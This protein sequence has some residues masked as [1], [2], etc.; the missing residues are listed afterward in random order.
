MSES[1][2]Q[3]KIQKIRQELNNFSLSEQNSL[4][5]YCKNTL[6]PGRQDFESSSIINL[7][8]PEDSK[9]SPIM[10]SSQ[11]FLNKDFLFKNQSD[12]ELK[13]SGLEHFLKNDGQLFQSV[14]EQE[15]IKHN[16]KLLL[17][18]HE[19]RA[20]Y[21]QALAEKDDLI[22]KYREK[23]SKDDSD[24]KNLRHGYLN[25]EDLKDSTRKLIS[26]SDKIEK[27]KHSLNKEN[28]VLKEKLEKAEE[29]FRKIKENF[30]V[31][32]EQCK[33]L[34]ANNSKS[35]RKIEELK[36]ENEFL[37]KALNK[38]K[39]ISRNSSFSPIKG[40]G[41]ST[42]IRKSGLM[43]KKP[44]F[45]SDGE[46]TERK[47]PSPFT[48]SCKFR[49]T[50]GSKKDPN[51]DSSHLTTCK[52]VKE[53]MTSLSLSSATLIIPQLKSMVEDLKSFKPF[54]AF[55][56]KM[57]K[58]VCQNSPPNTFKSAPTSKHSLMWI[59]RLIKEY[60]D[61]KSGEVSPSNSKIL[62]VLKA[63]LNTKNTDDIPKAISKLLVENEKLLKILEKVKGILKLGANTTL[64]EFD[65]ELELRGN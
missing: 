8:I 19:T 65:R 3:E 36:K 46:R 63:G 11:K 55:F 14:K 62:D 51:S 60:L 49:S 15:L 33:G 21:I 10:L 48:R 2:I 12:T 59:K 20:Y 23:M 34:I 32:E 56:Q 41:S 4:D 27:E 6:E 38:D 52:I 29:E 24:M 30:A 42:R 64:D 58:I 31:L 22:V 9:L 44:G 40:L 5:M 16:K 50:S 45:G 26:E 1:K 7:G 28:R 37:Y 43:V 57:Q 54:K 61:L 47:S 13:E 17:N 53:I 39:K 18:L 25:I 35:L